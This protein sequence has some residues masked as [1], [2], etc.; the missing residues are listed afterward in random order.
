MG[1]SKWDNLRDQHFGARRQNSTGSRRNPSPINT[2]CLG[3]WNS[4]FSATGYFRLS[5]DQRETRAQ[6]TCAIAPFYLWSKRALWSATLGGPMHVF[7]VEAARERGLHRH[8]VRR[9]IE[10]AR[11]VEG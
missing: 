2:S 8:E 6:A 9:N 5:L 3:S 11:R 10:I 7:I 1:A 4:A